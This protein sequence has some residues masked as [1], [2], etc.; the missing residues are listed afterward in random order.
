M[1]NQKTSVANY[2]IDSNKQETNGK[3]TILEGGKNID[4]TEARAEI[5]QY[6]AVQANLK[7]AI[8]DGALNNYPL[9]KVYANKISKINVFVFDRKFIE[10]FKDTDADK[11][12]VLTGVNNTEGATVLFAGCKVINDDTHTIKLRAVRPSDDPSKPVSE[13]PPTRFADDII[14]K[15]IKDL[16][17]NAFDIKDGELNIIIEK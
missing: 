15:V 10:R 1:D 16:D 3:A 17:S 4:L 11:Y 7:Q 14:S 12:V 9:A 6:I 5:R 8:A 2:N 13:H